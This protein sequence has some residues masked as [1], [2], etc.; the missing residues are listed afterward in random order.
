MR[1]IGVD[2]GTLN[3]GYGVIDEDNSELELVTCGVIKLP[4][5][6]PIEEKL[7]DLYHKLSSIMDVYKPDEVA[8][9]EPFVAGNARTALAIGRAQTVAILAASNRRLPVNRYAPSQVKLQVTNYGASSKQQV[10]EMVR[11][12]LKLDKC[13]TSEDASDALAVAICHLNLR[14]IASLISRDIVS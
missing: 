14:H 4:T 3:M 6:A 13:I 8:I 2:P 11:I 9:E 10:S 7:H 12:Q 5:K 1:I